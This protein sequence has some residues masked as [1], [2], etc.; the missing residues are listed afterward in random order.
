MIQKPIQNSSTCE[1]GLFSPETSFVLDRSMATQ[2]PRL[3]DGIKKQRKLRVVP[4]K[5]G[6]RSFVLR[7]R[8]LPKNSRF[9]LDQISMSFLSPEKK[10][11]EVL[12]TL[13]Q[14]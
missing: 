7:G 11:Q 1:F 5:K 3:T 12:S 2:T 10:L 13:K 4:Q 6:D 14:V 9:F 8:E